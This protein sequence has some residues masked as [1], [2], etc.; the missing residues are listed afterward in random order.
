MNVFSAKKTTLVWT[1]LF[2]CMTGCSSEDKADDGTSW[3][4][5]ETSEEPLAFDQG[6]QDFGPVTLDM[7]R[8]SRDV[9]P[10]QPLPFPK[11]PACAPSDAMTGSRLRKHWDSFNPNVPL[12]VQVSDTWDP[13]SSKGPTDV[14]YPNELMNEVKKLGLDVV[15]LP[16]VSDP[17]KPGAFNHRAL[18]ACSA[19]KS[20]PLIL[21]RI[22][23]LMLHD[24]LESSCVV[25]SVWLS[26][27]DC[28]MNPQSCV[29]AESCDIYKWSRVLE[30]DADCLM[31]STAG[32][33][34]QK[35]R[36]CDFASL[37]LLDY[38]GDYWQLSERCITSLRGK[39]YSGTMNKSPCSLDP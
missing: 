23:P 10:S 13:R 6:S 25:K 14:S 18:A 17:E 7:S 24:W 9:G 38:K 4:V 31:Y 30:E 35:D 3:N 29:E 21:V 15:V 12:M 33:W 32:C 36:D 5:I 22:K 1:C 11:R 27:F 16:F 37:E 2:S 28:E 39:H 26:G 8:H 34:Q 20:C 19:V